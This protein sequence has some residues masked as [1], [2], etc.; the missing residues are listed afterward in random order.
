MR[1]LRALFYHLNWP[2]R[3]RGSSFGETNSPQNS[4]SGSQ[5]RYFI[6]TLTSNTPLKPSWDTTWYYR[7]GLHNLSVSRIVPPDFIYS[8]QTL[9]WKTKHIHWNSSQ[10]SILISLI[11]IS[12]DFVVLFEPKLY[13]QM[14][15]TIPH[16]HSSQTYLKR[17][18]NPFA[19]GIHTTTIAIITTAKRNIIAVVEVQIIPEG[20]FT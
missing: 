20:H 2:L 13:Q 4:R 10:D 9:T 5:G 6:E 7:L 15:F 18:F 14:V 12:N 8:M 17:N 1:V 16:L 19:K 3:L 11:F